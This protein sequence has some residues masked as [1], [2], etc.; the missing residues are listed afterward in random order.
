MKKILTR[1]EQFFLKSVVLRSLRNGMMATLP[2]LIIGSVFM[3][4]ASL[5]SLLPFI[6]A[7]SEKVYNILIAPYNLLNGVIGIAAVFAIAY[8]HAKTKKV[9][10][11]FGGLLA[12][13]T[14]L[15]V[16][17]SGN[18]EQIIEA[19]YL[20]SSGI[21]T[22][23]I[24]AFGVVFILG[25]FKDKKLEITLPDTVPAA[26]ADPFNYMLSGGCAILVFYVINMILQLN[27]GCI[28]PE[29][30][31][32]V[33]TPL[34]VGSNTLWF[35]IIVNVFI[36]FMWFFGIHGFNIASGALIPI[37]LGNLSANA[38]A[39]AAGANP[40][41]II[42]F[43]MFIMSA[44]LFWFIPLMFMKCKSDQLRTV[45]KVSLI[46]SVFN[47]SEP[48][49]FG[50]PLVGNLTLLIPNILYVIYNVVVVYF[51]TS[52]GFL[53]YSSVFPATIIPHPI[54][55]YLATQDWR[56]FIVFAIQLIGSYMI[57]LPFVKKYDADLLKQEEMKVE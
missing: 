5:P 13:I 29:L 18:S 27:A 1:I 34:F 31:V 42:T 36:N 14:F 55:G 40:T 30:V 48:I 45:G 22:A 47:I 4:I 28:L 50:A 6:P 57:W 54:F 32:N 23:I 35:A 20:G 25:F 16:T 44:N 9:N 56:I 2:L 8:Y 26:V 43:S 3:I 19:T 7:Y 17:N 37:L 39:V 49:I 51:A 24:V 46:P 11:L 21:F 10:Q 41:N 33:L 38:E 52:L 12:T 15:L 53:G